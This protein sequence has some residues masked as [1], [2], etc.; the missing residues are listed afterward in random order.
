MTVINE[1]EMRKVCARE[2]DFR[3]TNCA[4][5]KTYGSQIVIS[6]ASERERERETHVMNEN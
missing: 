6:Y 5:K 3:P 1:S 2:A 4:E